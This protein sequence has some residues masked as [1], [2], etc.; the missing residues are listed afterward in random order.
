LGFGSKKVDVQDHVYGLGRFVALGWSYEEA[1]YVMV[2]RRNTALGIASIEC[3]PL[4]FQRGV[5]LGPPLEVSGGGLV[6]T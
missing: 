1:P 6:G 5:R 3:S 2:L 4:R